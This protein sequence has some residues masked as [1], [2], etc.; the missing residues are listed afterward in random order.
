MDLYQSLDDILEDLKKTLN[1]LPPP[2]CSRRE[3][4]TNWEFMKAIKKE[5]ILSFVKMINGLSNTA[6]HE[7]VKEIEQL[8]LRLDM[9]QTQEFAEGDKMNIMKRN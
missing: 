6:I 1:D 7:K 5:D 9:A 8:A 3:I 4:F 2:K